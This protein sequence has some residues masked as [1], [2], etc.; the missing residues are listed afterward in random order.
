LFDF[1]QLGW[2]GKVI[3]EHPVSRMNEH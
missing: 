2:H 1:L 3:L